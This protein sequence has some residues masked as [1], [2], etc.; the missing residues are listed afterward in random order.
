VEKTLVDL[1]VSSISE[2]NLKLSTSSNFTSKLDM[3][4]NGKALDRTVVEWD[5]LL[6]LSLNKIISINM[7]DDFRY[8]KV[9]YNGWQ[10]K[11]TLGIGF[12]FSLL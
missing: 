11:E 4:W 6:T 12:A 5:N 7:E 2:L 8:D 3:F 1:G 10:I 9:I